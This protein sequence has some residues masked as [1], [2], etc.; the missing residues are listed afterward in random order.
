MSHR[1]ETIALPTMRPGTQRS[2]RVHR[3]GNV[4]G[5]PKAYLQAALYADE[6]PG[7]LVAHHLL[8][9][10][11][12]AD[13]RGEI[14]GEVV[15][16]P[17]A[18]P[19]GIG[20]GDFDRTWPDLS[21]GLREAVERMLTDDSIA[22]VRVIRAA[23]ADRIAMMRNKDEHSALRQI[24][25]G[26]AYDADIVIDLQCNDEALL[27][28]YMLREDRRAGSDLAAEL[29]AAAC[30]LSD[31][32]DV[33]R[34]D[35]T[36]ALPWASLR[37]EFG[38]RFPIPAACLTAAVELRGRHDVS[39][40]LALGDAEAL[41]RFLQRRKLIAGKPG[42]LPPPAK[43]VKL[44]SLEVVRAPVAGLVSYKVALGDSLAEG[45]LVAEVIDPL[46]EDAAS[47]RTPVRT[48]TGGTVLVR[49][50]TK[51]A[52]PSDAIVTIV[53]FAFSAFPG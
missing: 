43:A 20:G 27:H 50:L 45:D 42:P 1:I 15:L 37:A 46:A 5:R 8:A 32:P 38:K 29:G 44:E 19:I 33:D 2:L 31:D 9:L 26:F 10:L 52:S 18:D 13:D 16:V 36:F 34:F 3:F 41:Y 21:K 28:V 22:N 49:H 12:K 47:A 11:R 24:L 35:E 30:L 39:D 48:R 4:G 53:P 6:L 14:K 17:V 7:M 40:R 23:L 25:M 51:L